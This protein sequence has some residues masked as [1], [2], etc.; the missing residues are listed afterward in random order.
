MEEL[1][2][3]ITQLG[4]NLD[5]ESLVKIARYWFWKDVIN[6]IGH[7]LIGLVLFGGIILGAFVCIRNFGTGKW[8]F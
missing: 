2:N 1:L 4:V 8:K 5:T 7:Q 3:K 6:S